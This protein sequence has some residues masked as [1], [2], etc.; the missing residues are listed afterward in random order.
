MAKEALKYSQ[1]VHYYGFDLFETASRETDKAELNIK[2]HHSIESI[3]QVLSNFAKNNNGFTF[4]LFKG[5]TNDTLFD[6]VIDL[7]FIDGGHSVNTIQN[8]YSYLKNSKVVVFDDYYMDK[9]IV[10]TSKWGCNTIVD[11]LDN[12]T[13]MPTFDCMP[14]IGYINLVVIEKK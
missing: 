7:A 2:P 10:D 5:N 13:I 1:T 9:D 12:M 8:D 14:N 11:Q 4:D 6:L 3:T